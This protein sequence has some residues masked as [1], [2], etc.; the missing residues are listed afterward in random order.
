MRSHSEE[1]QGITPSSQRSSHRSRVVKYLLGVVGGIILSIVAVA[2]WTYCSLLSGPGE[3]E[4]SDGHPFRSTEAKERYLAFEGTMVRRWPIVSEERLV[5]TSFGS[6][7]IRI[8]GPSDAPPLILLPGGGSNSYIWSANIAALSGEYRT[9]ALDNIWDFGRSVPTRRI[10]SG[11]DFSGWL[12][13]LFDT[14]RLGK[15]I[16][17]VGYSYGGWVSSQYVL[18]HPERVKA[19]VL[20]AP[21]Y[22]ILPLP[23]A[24]IWGMVST[25]IPMRYP[26]EKMLSWV[27]K[28]L[29]ES[30]ADGKA[31]VDERVEYVSIAFSCFKFKTP[32]NPTVLS[33]AELQGIRIRLLYLVGEH[34]TCYDAESAVSR[35]ARVAPG[36]SVELIP[37]TG[38]DLMFTHT[39]V[40]NRK[41][42][43]FLRH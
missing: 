6:T 13:E 15:E 36:I 19:A 16:R 42:L 43:E 22:T 25:L 24:Y 32:V 1:H 37:G 8:S 9:Y 33:D 41:I 4:M 31:M 40:V 18:A 38:H 14:L 11:R 10:Q 28:D 23:A 35:L 29:A 39:D 7:F 27:W 34:E 21:A 5:K 30:G 17:I 12:D 20:I 3:M 26:K 2:M